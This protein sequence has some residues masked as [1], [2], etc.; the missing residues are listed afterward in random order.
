MN[1]EDGN[2]SNVDV[3][4]EEFVQITV[5]PDIQLR[6]QARVDEFC[7]K[8]QPAKVTLK[9]ATAIQNRRWFVGAATTA[10]VIFLT[11]AVSASC[12]IAAVTLVSIA[13]DNKTRNILPVPAASPDMIASLVAKGAYQYA[14]SI[15][16]S[17][18][19]ENL[20]I[21]ADSPRY[22]GIASK[23]IESYVGVPMKTN[24]EYDAELPLTLYCK[25]K[26]VSVVNDI[27]QVKLTIGHATDVEKTD[28]VATWNEQVWTVEREIKL[29]ETDTVHLTAPRGKIMPNFDVQYRVRKFDGKLE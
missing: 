11:I 12:V 28:G 22:G 9:S 15:R 20:R 10:S 24:G 13:Q 8:P 16:S 21:G 23:G 5:P 19:D 2:R 4:L 29:N 26:V 17:T 3:I 1:R 27:A 25:I 18:D 14:V 7:D 6:L